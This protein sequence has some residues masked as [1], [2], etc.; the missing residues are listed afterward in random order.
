MRIVSRSGRVYNYSVRTNRITFCCTSDG[1]S[2]DLCPVKY[3][4]ATDYDFG[5]ISKFTLEVTQQC[6]LRCRYCI[7]SGAYPGRR[8]HNPAEMSS[9]T[10]EA[11]IRFIKEHADPKAPVV[12]ICFY[13]GEALLQKDRIDWMICRLKAE[14]TCKFEYSLSTNGVLLTPEVVEWI[15]SIPSMRVTVTIDGDEAVHDANRVFPSGRGSF[16]IVMEKLRYFKTHYPDEYDSRIQFLSTVDS[17]SRLPALSRF[18]DSS[19]LLAG[20]RPVHISSIIPTFKGKDKDGA[21]VLR[22]IMA[23]YDQALECYKK[24]EKNVLT[25]ELERL[26]GVVSRRVF[27]DLPEEQRFFTCCHTPYSCFVDANGKLFVCERFSVDNFVGTL[28]DGFD[29]A[30]VTRLVEDFTARRNRYCSRCWAK[31]LC[32]ICATNLNHTAP[33]FCTL[34]RRER[35]MLRLALLYYIEMQ[36]YKCANK[37]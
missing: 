16:G 26:V 13:G 23:V 11:A 29:K 12:G 6:N 22:T 17:I 28:A 1:Q 7:Y 9:E 36:E 32:R 19:Q 35:V 25:D 10:L 33:E 3:T 4:A 31:R 5:H 20:H 27:F 8:T 34:C 24:G 15:C 18:W 2:E 21:D 30:R 37:R 14:K